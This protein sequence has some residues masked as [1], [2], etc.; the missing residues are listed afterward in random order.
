MQYKSVDLQLVLCPVREPEAQYKHY[1]NEIYKCWSQVWEAAYNEAKYKKKSDNLKSDAFTRNDYAAA[2][3]HKDECIG[4]MLYRHV[5]LNLLSTHDD[6]FFAQW[7]EVHRKAL[8]K[9]G[10]RFIV[11]GNLAVSPTYRN[12]NL[13]ISLKDLIVGTIAEITLQSDADAAIATP[14]RDRNVHESCYSWGAIPIAQ[15]VPW[16]CDI[17]IDLVAFCKAEVSL[18]NDQ[19]LRPLLDTLWHNKLV[20]TPYTFESIE[21]MKGTLPYSL[22][23]NKV[24]KQTG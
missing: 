17:Q 4:L 5:D 23:N 7:S 15:D 8:S 9:L 10:S 19:T 20:V 14:R 18:R 12:K 2:V 1:Y 6:S 3:F 22:Q 24:I 16:G 21:K 13:G 11:S